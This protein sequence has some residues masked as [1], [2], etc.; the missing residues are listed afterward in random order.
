MIKSMTGFGK[1]EAGGFIVEMRSVNH[2]FLDVS[3][4]M[5]RDLLALESRI[6]KAVGDRLS[7]G[8]VE[9][10]VNR[11][12]ADEVKRAF[13]LNM[14]AARQYVGA[15]N[16]LKSVF[17]LPGEVDLALI[18][19]MKDVI[20][21]EEVA[22]D[23]EAAWASLSS[24]LSGGMDML[25]KMR[26]LEGEALA[27]DIASRAAFIESGIAAVEKL[28]PVTVQE[29]ARKLRERVEKLSDGIELD[30]ARLHQEVVMFA[31]RCDVT[32]EVVR[33]RSHLAQLASMLESDEPVGRKMDF[34]LQEINREVNTMGSKASDQGIAHTVVGMKA[35]LEKVREQVQNIE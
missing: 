35:E 18:T 5:P 3:V 31:D 1:A 16:E 32:E 29:Y 21:E 11:G 15:M 9:I 20:T 13:K 22:E 24:A 8:R 27:K 14:D 23:I 7:R 4:K 25:E 26:A 30:P 28:S 34:L 17:D 10:F 12:G 6:K 33:G 2:K 19:S